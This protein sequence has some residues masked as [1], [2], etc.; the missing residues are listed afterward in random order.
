MYG[1]GEGVRRLERV[2]RVWKKVGE[3]WEKGGR[4]VKEGV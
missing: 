1:V 4:G 3:G 2:C